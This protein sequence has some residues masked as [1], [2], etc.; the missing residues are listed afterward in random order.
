MPWRMLLQKYLTQKLLESES[1]HQAV[2][3]IHR[4]VHDVPSFT[5]NLKA[6]TTQND[7]VSK[8]LKLGQILLDEIKQAARGKLPKS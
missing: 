6:N 7:K 5:Q 2:R 3:A 1:F 4:N 8:A